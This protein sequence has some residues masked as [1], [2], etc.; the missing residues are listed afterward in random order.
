MCARIRPFRAIRPVRDKVHLVASRPYYTYSK[1]ILNAKLIENPYTFIHIINPEFRKSDKTEPN[2][3]ERFQK[4][5]SKFDEFIEKQIFIKDGTPSYYLYRQTVDKHE[6]VGIIAGSCIHDYL[7]GKIKVHE[8]TLTSREETFKMYLDVCGFNAEPVLLTHQ[9]NDDVMKI[10]D[11]VMSERPEYEFTTSDTIKHEVWLI[12]NEEEIELL[13]NKFERLGDVYIADGHHRSS[14]SVLLGKERMEANPS[15]TGTEGYN[16]FLSYL[17]PESLLKIYDFN[18]LVK[19]LGK[20]TEEELISRL[21]DHFEVTREKKEFR[22]QKKHEFSMY[23]NRHWYKLEMKKTPV[24]D[25]PA[26]LL[27][28]YILNELILDPIFGI[29]D[30]KTD[31]NISFLSGKSGTQ[32][33]KKKVDKGLAEVAFGLFP[34][35][36]KELMEVADSGNIMPPKSTYIDPKL[37]SGLTIYD[38]TD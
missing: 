21:Q 23:L 4:V 37:R 27:D 22:P 24:S 38:L 16:F 13:T 35:S 20:L 3:V 6:F 1:Q 32:G 11:D 10:Y 17:I 34:V 36:V 14:S 30:L 9:D 5:K 15:H 19:S 31:P 7:D 28:P 12:Q 25:N 26:H 8:Q 18:R 29:S 33:L 2:S